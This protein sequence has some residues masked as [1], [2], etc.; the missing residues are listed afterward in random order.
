MTNWWKNL[1]ETMWSGCGFGVEKFVENWFCGKSLAFWCEK[2]LCVEEKF[3]LFVNN[4]GV[5]GGKQRQGGIVDIS[6]FSTVS[7]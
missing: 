3:C 7:T 4:N 5:F 1:C 2:P 6:A